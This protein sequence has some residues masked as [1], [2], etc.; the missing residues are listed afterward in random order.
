MCIRDRPCR[1]V[2]GRERP[3]GRKG[4][5]RPVALRRTP[6]RGN[7]S[8]HHR[9]RGARPDRGHHLLLDRRPRCRVPLTV[10]DNEGGL[11]QSVEP[12]FVSRCQDD[13]PNSAVGESGS[14]ALGTP[15]KVNG[16]SA[17]S[18]A[19]STT[20]ISPGWMSPNR[21]F[22]V[23]YTHLAG[24]SRRG[25]SGVRAGCPGALRNGR[26]LD[27]LGG[28]RGRPHPLRATTGAVSYT[29]LVP[30]RANRAGSTTFRI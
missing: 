3:T 29:H 28:V 6:D 24:T 23:S 26:R 16:S 1:L 14:G 13:C 20:T 17:P 7:G 4:Q 10:L 5:S 8:G 22:S 15:L 25:E 27:G 19:T 9:H 11:D 21:I 2:S 18:A 12:S 30:S